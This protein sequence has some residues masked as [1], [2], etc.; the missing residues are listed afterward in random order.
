MNRM[1]IRKNI[2]YMSILLFLSFFAGIYYS[3]PDFAFNRDGTIKN[4]GL[5]YQSKTVVPLWL[6][7]IILAIFSYLGVIYYIMNPKLV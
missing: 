2:I 7:V 6:I 4:F 5:G 1:F 3:K